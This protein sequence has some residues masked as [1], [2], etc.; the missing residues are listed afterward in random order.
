VAEAVAAQQ[1]C[2]INT[3][4]LPP[5]RYINGKKPIVDADVDPLQILNK[6]QT[7]SERDGGDCGSNGV[8]G[9]TR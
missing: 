6:D 8:S 9:L 4:K 7:T 1:T 5:E 3:F 2:G